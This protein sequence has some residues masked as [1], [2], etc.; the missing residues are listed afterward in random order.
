M[1]SDSSAFRPLPSLRVWLQSTSLLAV[2][3]G[4][5][6]LFVV[7]SNLR[8]ERRLQAHQQ[9]ADALIEQQRLIS[10]TEPELSGL[11]LQLTL[12]DSGTESA[13]QLQLDADGSA[14]MVSRQWL[15]RPGRSP[16]VEVR[17]NI[18]EQWRQDRTDQLLLVAA[19]GGSMLFTALLLRLVLQ[20]GLMVPLAALREQLNRLEADSLNQAPIALSHQPRELQPIAEAFD[21]LQSRLAKAWE[22]ERFFVDGVAHELRTPISVISGHAQQ[23]S[24]QPLPASL[25]QPLALIEAEAR[26]MGQL[27]RVLLEL[28]RNDSGRLSLAMQHLDPEDLLLV[29]Y[30][31]LLPLAPDRLQLAAPSPTALM[32]IDADPDRLQQCLAA[33]VENAIAYASGPIQLFVTAEP[34][35]IVLHVQD[36]G[37][38]ISDQEKAKVLERFTRGS[39]ATGTRGSGLGLS[40]VQQL[41]SLM[42]ADVVIADA[43]GG[44]ADVQLVFRRCETFAGGESI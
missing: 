43:P 32:P 23:L 37:A 35:R 2:V 16:L 41:I 39:T 26:R 13:P 28:A 38:G 10:S 36:Q 14:W 18:T 20:R 11:G 15:N 22:Q 30:E 33:L 8:Q 44:G 12:L 5:S 42:G 29:A 1:F 21:D 40:L 7:S 9:Q 31:R 6:L 34:E 24:D 17:Q 4:Y 25:Q 27:L 3:A 19:A